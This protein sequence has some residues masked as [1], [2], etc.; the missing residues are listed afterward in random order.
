MTSTSFITRVRA[1][2]AHI[3]R[4]AAFLMALCLVFLLVRTRDFTS[5]GT[6]QS[7]ALQFPE[8]GLMALGVMLTMITGGIDLS[9]VGV[10]NMTSIVSAS[11]ML[12]LAPRGG[13]SI[14]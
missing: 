6:W 4:L 5:V 13:N 7:M 11:V 8:Y 1:R 3:L 10:A 9:S 14:S 2:D 12:T